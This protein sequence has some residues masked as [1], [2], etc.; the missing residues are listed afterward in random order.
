MVQVAAVTGAWLGTV[1]HPSHVVQILSWMRPA[2]V[3][4]S[5]VPP[6]EVTKLGPDPVSNSC[7]GLGPQAAPCLDI[8]TRTKSNGHQ[9]PRTS[10]S[11]N[12]PVVKH[13]VEGSRAQTPSLVGFISQLCL[14]PEVRPPWAL[15]SPSIEL[16]GSLWGLKELK[17]PEGVG[18]HVLSAHL[19]LFI[20]VI[21][22]F[23]LEIYWLQ[24]ALWQ[25]V[26]ASF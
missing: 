23:I 22:H 13:E 6:A 5:V 8:Q 19:V 16:V 15:V 14:S 26:A 21:Y 1:L 20:L 12:D 2:G 25:L 9:R 18:L 4:R 24:V 10:L 7:P 3:V 17:Q 11:T